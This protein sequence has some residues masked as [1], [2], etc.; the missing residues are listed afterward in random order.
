M[1]QTVVFSM[2]GLFAAAT[3]GAAD[4]QVKTSDGVALAATAFG[5]G[6]K[7]VLLVHG[8]GR[9]R[10]DW[11][12]F[13]QKL[14]NNGFHV[15]TVDLRGHGASG[16]ALDEAAWPLMV[17]DVNA[18]ADWLRSK[19]ANHVTIIGAEVGANLA[20]SAANGNDGINSVI[21]LSPGLNIHG[22]KVSAA[23]SAYGERPLLLIADSTDATSSRAAGLI[24]DKVT[25]KK[26]LEL[27]EGIGSGVKML[28]TEA[29][30]EGLVVGWMND[31]YG[32]SEDLKGT[33]REVN[34]G[35]VS[36]DITTSGTRFGE[37][38]E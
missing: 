26:K 13:G 25:G 5:Q 11:S 37:K 20:F 19:G 35:D 12:S 14:S 8:Q 16:G 31:A 7:G 22:V 15:L 24:A 32:G 3:A 27:V 23:I 29:S 17:N 18:S 28:N 9:T 1:M 4:V 34:S 6:E 21:M 30:V 38:S 33:R 2:L 10:A 36:D